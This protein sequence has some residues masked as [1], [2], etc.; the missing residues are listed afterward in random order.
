MPNDGEA[1]TTVHRQMMTLFVVQQAYISFFHYSLFSFALIF[2]IRR[3][4]KGRERMQ[5]REKDGI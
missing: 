3:A 4:E 1:K 2:N 5:E